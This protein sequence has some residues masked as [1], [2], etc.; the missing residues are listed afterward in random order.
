MN[1]TIP[2]PDL[3]IQVAGYIAGIIALA[4]TYFQEMQHKSNKAQM[5]QLQ[6]VV[7]AV[8]EAKNPTSPNPSLAQMGIPLEQK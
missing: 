8:Q 7:K 6:N 1:L 2:I 4:W 5:A 3:L